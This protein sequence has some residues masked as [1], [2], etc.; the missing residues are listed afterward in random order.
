[1][2][3]G[4]PPVIKPA[5]KRTEFDDNFL[6]PEDRRRLEKPMVSLRKSNFKMSYL[7][8][9]YQNTSW[10]AD[11]TFGLQFIGSLVDLCLVIVRQCILLWIIRLCRIRIP[12]LQNISHVSS[13]LIPYLNYFRRQK[14]RITLKDC[15]NNNYFTMLF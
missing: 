10:F 9:W 3:F 2:A 13:D 15:N 14:N 6:S 7:V 12:L 4:K 11:N 1:M 8:E 5:R